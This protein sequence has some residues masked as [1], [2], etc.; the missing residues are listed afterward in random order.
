MNIGI[1]GAG[2]VGSTLGKGWAARGHSV[3]L[4]SREPQSEKMQALIREIG[5]NA[6]A[7]TVQQTLNYANLSVIAIGWPAVIDAIAQAGDW[8]GKVI[9]DTTNRFGDPPPNS[10]GSAAQDIAHLTGASVVKAFNTIGMEHMVEPQFDEPP[11]M[12]IAG[13]LPDAKATASGLI[14]ELG[15]EVIDAGP[16]SNASMLE[17]LARLWVE[18]AYSQLQNRNI[19]FRLMRR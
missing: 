7:G 9:I 1:F 18:L 4:S 3:M 16:L 13:D 5:P 10:V 15:L 17:E 6:Q 12:F 8:S 14:A 19:A 11:T 2:K